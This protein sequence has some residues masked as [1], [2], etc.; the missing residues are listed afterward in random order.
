MYPHNSE[1]STLVKL[2]RALRQ[3]GLERTH[4][5]RAVQRGW[6]KGGSTDCK[7]VEVWWRGGRRIDII[8][9]S[10][11]VAPRKGT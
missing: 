7:H 10:I 4:T 2:H 1:T 5:A 3:A 8:I 6:R 11:R 9:P